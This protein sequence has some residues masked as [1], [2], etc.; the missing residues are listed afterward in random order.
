MTTTNTLI[1]MEILPLKI[2]PEESLVFSGS[3]NYKKFIFLIHFY[4]VFFQDLL[5]TA[6]YEVARFLRTVP[7]SRK[8]IGSAYA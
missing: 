2:I 5:Y 3:Q 4:D 1:I 7:A 8:Y 6:G